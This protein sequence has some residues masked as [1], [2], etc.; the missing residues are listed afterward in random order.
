MNA[1]KRHKI[2]RSKTK[3]SLLLTATVV[4]RESAFV[5]SLGPHEAMQK[6]LDDIFV[7]SGGITEKNSELG[8]PKSF[9]LDSKHTCPLFWRRMLS[10]F[11]RLFTMET[12]LK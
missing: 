10:Y 5:L 4:V 9:I 3:D 11:P 7:Y 1:G 8:K 6:G 12:P 2:P